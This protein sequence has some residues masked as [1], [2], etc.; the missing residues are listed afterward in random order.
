MRISTPTMTQ[1]GIDGM[2]DNQ[3]KLS[4]VQQQ[5]AS[6][7]RVINPSDDP[8]AAN[9]M[10]NL[11]KSLEL[12]NQYQKNADYARNRMNIEEKTLESAGNVL[13]RVRELVVQANHDSLNNFD[14]EA[15]A[16]EVDERL[17]ELIGLANARDGAGE[18]LFSGSKGRTT[19]FTHTREEGYQ[20]NGDEKVRYLQIG[21]DY[22][23]QQTNSGD[24]I[25][26]RVGNG[27]RTFATGYHP[28]NAGSGTI[29]EGRVTSQT[30]LTRHRYRIDLVESSSGI[31]DAP[32]EVRVLDEDR[33][34]FVV[35][36]DDPPSG[37][38]YSPGMEVNFDGIAVTL[39]GR[40]A[41][42]DGFSV[43]PSTSQSVFD[44]VGN[45]VTSLKA[46]WDNPELR[47]KSKMDMDNALQELTNALD[48]VLDTRAEIGARINS[49]DSQDFVN[50]AYKLQMEETLSGIEDLDYASATG[51]LNMRMVG[52]QAAQQVY[53]KVKELSLFNY[54]R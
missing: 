3:S 18:Y 51:E 36:S 15:V 5:M 43:R 12:T 30:D 32:P 34:E 2:L 11:R 33:G 40:P 45:I 24:S 8:V 7:K 1:R 28:E 39:S 6:G 50:D 13:Q 9:Q 27:N 16:K 47:A 20:Y 53:S 21:P 38:E 10:L 42:G 54:V 35:G 46:N 23:V 48:N 22:R 26:M 19:P 14:R 4:N 44:T 17:R 52:L 37:M 41:V 49:V 25:F 31:P 29:D